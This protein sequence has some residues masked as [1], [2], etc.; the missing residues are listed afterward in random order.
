[1]A[2][3]C[4]D[5]YTITDNYEA[6][7]RLCRREKLGVACWNSA[8]VSATGER[9]TVDLKA[10]TDF[11]SM[12]CKIEKSYCDRTDALIAQTRAKPRCDRLKVPTPACHDY[13]VQQNNVGALV[14]LCDQHHADT[15]CWDAAIYFKDG[16]YVK[17]DIQQAL[18]YLQKACQWDDDRIGDRHTDPRY[19]KA[20][21]DPKWFLS[22]P[23]QRSG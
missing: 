5:Y 18:A 7:E 2:P 21:A 6:L 9:G 16:Q 1:V 13:Y 4:V 19:D 10:A 14:A 12:A 20:C 11:A 15:A 8:V 17:R 22:R 23:A 3:D